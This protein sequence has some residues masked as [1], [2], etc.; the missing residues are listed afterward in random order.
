MR[1]KVALDLLHRRIE[2]WTEAAMIEPD[3]S[4]TSAEG[5]R[6]Y[7]ADL[8]AFLID[9]VET[10]EFGDEDVMIEAT[11]AT[12][13]EICDELVRAFVELWD[14]ADFGE[15]PA[16]IEIDE[17]RDILECIADV[18]ESSV[19]EADDEMEVAVEEL[20]AFLADVW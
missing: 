5:F 8:V 2:E 12:G 19:E 4:N 6:E 20:E 14:D 9:L 15:R 16:D 11:A 17:V 13:R 10:W 3:V 18:L 1:L 7:A